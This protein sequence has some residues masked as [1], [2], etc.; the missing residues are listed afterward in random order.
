MMHISTWQAVCAAVELGGGKEQLLY[1]NMQAG[2]EWASR[3]AGID[4]YFQGWLQNHTAVGESGAGETV[5]RLLEYRNVWN[6]ISPYVTDLL[7]TAPHCT[8]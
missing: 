2:R 3:Q 6:F 7:S 5:L 4:A 8:N 1:D